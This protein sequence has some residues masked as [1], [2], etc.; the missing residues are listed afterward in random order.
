MCRLLSSPDEQGSLMI[1][2]FPRTRQSKSVHASRLERLL[3]STNLATN[4]I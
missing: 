2:G 4:L 1:H 3:I